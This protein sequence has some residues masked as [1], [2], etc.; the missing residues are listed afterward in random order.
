MNLIIEKKYI[1]VEDNPAKNIYLK[2]TVSK[3]KKNKKSYI[4]KILIYQMNL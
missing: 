2:E 4:D 3:F 1:D